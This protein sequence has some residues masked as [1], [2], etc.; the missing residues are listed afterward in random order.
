LYFHYWSK[1][2]KNKKEVVIELTGTETQKILEKDKE[3]LLEAG[4]DDC[5]NEK[6]VVIELTRTETQKIIEKDKETLLEAGGDDCLNEKDNIKQV[7]LN[8]RLYLI[9]KCLLLRILF[10]WA[11]LYDIHN[12]KKKS[13]TE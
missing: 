4:G 12:I 5:L 9:A 7:S 11:L 10:I 3:T 8:R 1:N 13:H 2:N 6:E